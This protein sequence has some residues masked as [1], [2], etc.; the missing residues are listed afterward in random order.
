MEDRNEQN[1]WNFLYMIFYVAIFAGLVW[2]LWQYNGGLPREISYFDLALIVLATFRLIRLFVY[3]KVTRW[4][5]DMFAGFSR[6]PGKT[7]FD[8]LNCPWC[9]GLWI[10]TFLTFFYFLIPEFVWFPLLILAL[11]GVATLLQLFANMIGWKA[12]LGKLRAHKMEREG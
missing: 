1:I 7:L 4:M 8:L 2:A 3:D 12:E 9:L 5:R 6:G 11:A 10:G